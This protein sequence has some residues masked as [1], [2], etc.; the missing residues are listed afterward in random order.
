MKPT[1]FAKEIERAAQEMGIGRRELFDSVV[2]FACTYMCMYAKKLS[3]LYSDIRF[4]RRMVW[5]SEVKRVIVNADDYVQKTSDLFMMLTQVMKAGE[6]FEDRLTAVYSEFLSGVA[7]QFMSPDNLG[8]MLMRIMACDDPMDD[9]RLR[10]VSEPTC[11]TGALALG[12]LQDVYQTKGKAGIA[13]IDLH[14][15]DIDI[16]LI[17]IAMFQVMFHTIE[18]RVPLGRLVI[19]CKNL[20][21]EYQDNDR[22]I[23]TCRKT[24]GIEREMAILSELAAAIG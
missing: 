1:D 8:Q 15:N 2:S 21:T 24:S 5:E 4:T 13:Q 17:K 11:G 7:G 10:T 12:L 19:E 6:P 18:H 14:L 9:S 23:F 16:R 22:V 20:I 3:H